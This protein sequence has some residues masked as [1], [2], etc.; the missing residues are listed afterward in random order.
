[1]YARKTQSWLKHLDFILLDV[2]CLHI[3]FVLAYMVRHGMMNPYADANY[4]NL[5]L[6]YTLVDMTVLIANRTMKNVLKRGFYKEME[7]TVRN[8]LLVTLLV[9]LYMFSVQAGVVYSRITFY[10]MS[11]FYLLIAYSVRL[12]WKQYLLHRKR[13][14]CDTAIFF[15][16]T[17]ARA[18]RIIQR[19]Q[20]DSLGDKAIQGLCIL[21]RNCT[22]QTI[23]GIRVTASRESLIKHLCEIWVDEV[24]VSLPQDFPHPS[25]LM[26]A[27]AAMGIVV[28]MEMEQLEGDLWQHQVIEEFGGTTVRTISMTMATPVQAVLKRT[29]DIIGGITGCIATGLLAVVIGPMIY[30]KSPGPIFFVQTRVGK[31]GRKFKIYKF[32][33]MYLDAES[34]KAELMKENRIKGGL[35]FKLDYDPRIIGCEKR[36]DGTIK[37]GIGNFIRDYSLDEFPQFFNVLKGDLSLCGTRPPTVDE[38]EKYELHHHARLAVK[39]GITGLWQVSGRSKITD[40]E[41]VVELDKKYIREWSMGLDFRIL[42]QTIK[43]VL[44][45]EGSM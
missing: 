34:R 17:E 2:L 16:T 32:R 24:F 43:V 12:L 19:F 29:L 39:P 25:E 21:D 23:A 36:P 22:G 41:E 20:N 14:S 5:S 44:G 9:S 28:H 33:S 11:V 42:L 26:S 31:N 38:W 6:V 45:K 27:M 40:F 7:Q 1:M 15:V 8:V 37:K 35:M 4:F 10:L 13:G 30:I 3:A 18:E